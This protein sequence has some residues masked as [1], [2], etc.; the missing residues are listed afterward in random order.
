MTERDS[1]GRIIRQGRAIRTRKMILSAAAAAFDDH[2]YGGTTIA[3]ICQRAGMTKGALYFHFDTKEDLAVAVLAAQFDDFTIPPRE[4]ALQELI[5]AGYLLCHQYKISSIQ[6]GAARIVMDE[7]SDRLGRKDSMQMWADIV[8]GFLTESRKRGELLTSVHIPDVGWFINAA[9]AGVQNMSQAFDGRAT[10]THRLT[11]MWEH[12]LPT[13]AVPSTL[14]KL[15]IGP[16]RYEMVAEE[17][18]ALHAN[19]RR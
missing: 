6:R 2:G 10:L 1:G 16:E 9:F 3:D 15:K 11:V 12:T 7:G 5:D 19:E 17:Y 13:I 4:L 14:G 8:I 18:E